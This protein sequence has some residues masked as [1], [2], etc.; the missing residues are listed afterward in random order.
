MNKDFGANKTTIEVI[1]KGTFEGTYFRDAY[2]GI[3]GK[4]YRK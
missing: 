4:R 1:K 2:S 3:N